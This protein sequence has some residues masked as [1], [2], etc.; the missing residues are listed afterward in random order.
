M[1]RFR[2]GKQSYL[3]WKI[4]LFRHGN[5]PNQTGKWSYLDM[6]NCPIQTGNGPIQTW[7]NNPIQT[8]KWSYLDRPIK[9]NEPRLQVYVCYD[10][11][12][13]WGLNDNA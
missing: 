2:H 13:R 9:I 7:E 12:I 10:D 4:V 6:E 5:N 3:D 11:V 1:V 8:G